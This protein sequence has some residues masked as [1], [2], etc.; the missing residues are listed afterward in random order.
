MGNFDR[1]LI[2]FWEIFYNNKGYIKVLEGLRIHFT[3]Q[4]WD[5]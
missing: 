1:K 3:L 2:K 5:L 4:F